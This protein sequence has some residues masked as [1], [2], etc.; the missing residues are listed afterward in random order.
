MLKNLHSLKNLSFLI[1]SFVLFSNTSNACVRISPSFTYTKNPTCGTP[2]TISLT[3]TSTGV[4]QNVSTY[5]WK[6]NGI[7]FKVVV[8]KAAQSYK[9]TAAGT[10]VFRLLVK[11]TT[12][13]SDSVS[14][15]IVITSTS[16]AVKD[17][18][19]N[20]SLSPV[21]E[22]CIQ[23]PF[24]PDTFGVKIIPFDTLKN[25][26][27]LW[28]DGASSSGSQ[29][30]ST[31]S[32]YH[33]YTTLGQF[34]LK[35]RTGTAPCY[36]TI[37]GTIINE[38]QPVAGMLGPPTGTNQGCV[39][40]K[41]RCVNNSSNISPGTTFTWNMGDGVSVTKPASTYKDTLFYT[42]KK[43]L[44]GGSITLTAA[45]SC[46]SSV[47]SWNPIKVGSKDSAIIKP[48]N[49]N[50][51]DLSVPMEWD[52]KTE[53]RYCLLP[54]VK[55]FKWDFGD[56]TGTSWSTSTAKQSHTYSAKGTYTVKLIDSNL[57]GKDTA[58]Y[59]FVIG[60]KPIAV[61]SSD[62]TSGCASLTVNFKD[63]STGTL[64]SRNWYFND[65]NCPP[66]QN[67]VSNANPT[68]VFTQ[69]GT[70]NVILTASNNCGPTYD[71]IKVVV[72]S[73]SRASFLLSS[74]GCSPVKIKFTNTTGE[75]FSKGYSYKWDFG[76]GTSSV[77]RDPPDKTY[78]TSGLYVIRLV[79]FDTCGNDTFRQNLTVYGKPK[80]DFSWPTQGVCKKAPF[81]F[82]NTTTG[83]GLNF[84]WSFG[85]NTG[86]FSQNN[87]FSISHTFDSAKSYTVRL[88]AE[89]SA[90]CRDTI[91]KT[92]TINPLPI[93]DFTIVNSNG[94]SPLSSSFTNTS[95]HNGLGG[96]NNM[97]FLWTFGLGST[98]TSKDA[99]ST[100]YNLPKK[101]T[102]Y[103]IKL[104][105]TNSYGCVDSITKKVTVY[106]Y[107][108]ANFSLSPLSGCAPLQVSTK[109]I[110][111]PNDTGS[112][113]IMSFIW[114]LRN[115]LTSK[116]I[117]TAFYLNA[118]LT[119]DT[120]HNVELV[121][122]SEH[123]CRDSTIRPITVF[124]KPVSS[125]I[126][127]LSSGCKPLSVNFTN[128]SFPN[129]TGSISIM[130]FKW[131]FTEKDTTSV[132]NPK[133][134][135]NQNYDF[136][137]VYNVKL[138][139]ISEHGCRDT[140]TYNITLHPD[141]KSNFKPSMV[142]GCGP[143]SVSFSN[144]SKNG[145]TFSWFVDNVKKDTT[146]NFTYVFQSRPIFDSI[147]TVKLTSLS[148]FGCKSDTFEFPI[149]ARSIPVASF[150]SSKDTFCYPDKIQFFN[151]SLNAYKYKW[152]LGDG[153]YTNLTN[154]S[155]FFIKNP[156]PSKDTTYFIWLESTSPNNCKDT[157]TGTMTVLPYPVPKFT[158]DKDNGCSPLTVQFNNQS[159]NSRDFIWYFGDGFSDKTNTPLHTYY[160]NGPRDTVYR[161]ILF[162]Y[163]LDCSDSESVLL[164]VYRP[165]DAYYKFD[166]V[167]PC[168]DGFFQFE[169]LS[170]NGSTYI[171]DF[172][173]GT[174]SNASD[175]L[176]LFPTSS[177]QDTIYN[178]K[179]TSI[180]PRL[181]RDSLV[182]QVK[183]PQRLF[184]DFVDGSHNLCIPGEVR[185]Q[186]LSK[187]AVTY[188]W[189]FGDGEGSA[190]RNPVHQYLREGVFKYKLKAFDPNGCSDSVA[191]TGIVKVAETPI[192]RFSFSPNKGKIPNSTIYFNSLSF[193]IV[194]LIYG[195]EFGDPGSG[196]NNTTSIKDPNHYF[197]DSGW[198]KVSHF[199]SNGTCSDTAVDYVRIDPRLPDPDFT[200]DKTVG[201]PPLTVQFTNK[202]LYADSFLWFFDD[203]EIS[204]ERD[205]VHMFKSAGKYTV[206]L[207]ATGPGGQGVIQKYQLITVL[208]SP[209]TFFVTTPRELYLPDA[210]FYTKNQ[211]SLGVQYYW[212]VFDKKG[213]NLGSSSLFEPSFKLFD[214]GK[215]D[216]RLISISIDGCRDTL[217][218]F[219]SVVVSPNGKIMIPT[220]FSPNKDGRNEIFIHKNANLTNKN[221]LF[222][223]FNRWGE[224]VFE[225]TDPLK[226]WDGFSSGQLCQEG[227]YVW[228]IKGH[229][230]SG[231]EFE[232][233]GTLTLIR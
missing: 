158:I 184:V 156:D 32:V 144:A 11:D 175:P 104:H 29:L 88:I 93:A 43:F 83:G 168:D 192:A 96:I 173:D 118:S 191:S 45:N 229:F 80:A 103:N 16:R 169:N 159:Q 108:K 100:F 78:T 66:G 151:Q 125:F 112:I 3:N 6:V 86:T 51:C 201:C 61:A 119:K 90:G 131:L 217:T 203:G 216:V 94:C 69:P 214:T 48:V 8:G 95:V 91:T 37:F 19:G 85:D 35:I 200:V 75:T 105:G 4:A 202:T 63:L 56:G 140:S 116:V 53:D 163:T 183:L 13:C 189:D 10:Y 132:V 220:A 196:G 146:F 27:I 170:T 89:T 165:T 120:I 137:T 55:N 70:Y 138:V 87:V 21:F 42:Y 67:N 211:S 23:S 62:K 130:K 134:V 123:G 117:D 153:T 162:T 167:D 218:Q 31:Q 68:H 129:D 49:P 124:P 97:T 147:Y 41:I 128:N 164:P 206:K 50:N 82:T 92:V 17:G 38:R 180:S 223:I 71:T 22:N 30:L 15:T 221:F 143:L 12:G 227:V 213:N 115:G 84:F 40:L 209:F 179:L 230:Y 176:H 174:S 74:S 126:T 122:I 198:F 46:G 79:S 64:T 208:N 28:G 188:I 54:N 26:L 172:N 141:A 73:K 20:F 161:A 195:W 177:S 9:I 228:R 171:W 44:C 76:D 133:F 58:K 101:D 233:N 1:L 149:I 106:P 226:G 160:N 142:A 59:T 232:D 114:K 199:V 210:R 25:Y 36:D 155:H 231:D 77:L 121:A 152:Y 225:T 212:D 110:S 181:C 135:F 150:I 148:P 111:V 60:D 193:S 99:S 204:K 207:V 205:P 98:S 157:S 107:P 5:T 139:G 18:L 14:T 182:R 39:P 197:T 185:F 136:D 215:Y 127:D 2:V 145:S 34:I 52:N 65:P 72:Y 81:T 222:Q 113:S 102:I 178:V 154:P 187:G 7:P 186:N 57:C 166:R 194:S 219:D 190:S 24:T 47:T 109:N 224:K 33:K